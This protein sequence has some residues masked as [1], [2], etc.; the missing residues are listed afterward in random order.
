MIDLKSL[1]K[2]APLNEEVKRERL[3]KAGSLSDEKTRELE[4]LCWEFIFSQYQ[5]KIMFEKEKIISEVEEG[6]RQFSKKDLDDIED[7]VLNELLQNLNAANDS[8]KIEEIREKLA[9]TSFGQ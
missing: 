9:N 5:S 8:G 4:D 2:V 1:A 6:K 3:E 7:T